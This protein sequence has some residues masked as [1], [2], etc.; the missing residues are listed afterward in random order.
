MYLNQFIFKLISFKVNGGLTE[1]QNWSNCDIACGPGGKQKR[2]RYCTNPIPQNG[3]KPCHGQKEET[4]ECRIPPCPINCE[5]SP[6]GG[7][8][9]CSITCG[10]RGA[11]IQVRHRHISQQA[12]YGGT[13]CP[14]DS[15]MTETR[16]CRHVEMPE[17]EKKGADSLLVHK[18]KTTY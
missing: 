13:K 14:S 4:R 7:W 18:C 2:Y 3:G 8:M 11:G 1:W 5:F 12:K 16:K 17:R 6:W 10:P 9:P 15:I